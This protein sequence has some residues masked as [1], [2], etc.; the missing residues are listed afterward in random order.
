MKKL[1]IIV[2][3]LGGFSFAEET[4][5]K[6]PG[7]FAIVLQAGAE[8]NEG[9][10]RA[11]HA[12]MYARELSENGY[13]VVLIFD[14]AGTGWAMEFSKPEHPF[15]THYKK[16]VEMGMVEEICDYCAEKFEI[17]EK[18]VE[19]QKMYLTGAYEGHPSL[20]KWIEKGYEVIVL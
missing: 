19:R 13:S 10:A 1:L 11:L 20:L 5:E 16:L 8:T 7:K 14:G 4:E 9:K 17:K 2:L 12:L 6:L 15:N 18:L 3:L